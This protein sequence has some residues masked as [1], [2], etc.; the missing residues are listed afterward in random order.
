M[1]KF[2]DSN[3]QETL[4]EQLVCEIENKVSP[5]KEIIA[6]KDFSS[7]SIFLN[8]Q[9]ISLE[10]SFYL[11]VNVKDVGVFRFIFNKEGFEKDEIINQISALKNMII[12]DV[13]RAKDKVNLLLDIVEK[14]CLLFM[15][16]EASDNSYITNEYFVSFMTRNIQTFI[17]KKEKQEVMYEV[18]LVTEEEQD[19]SPKNKKDR[20]ERK[21]HNKVFKK[22]F[23]TV[24]D[25]KFHLLLLLVSTTLFE[26]SIPLAIVNIYGANPI[27]IFLFICAVIGIGMDGYSY[28]DLF[29]TESPKSQSSLASYLSNLLGIG[30]GT[31]LFVLFY[32]LTE[33]AEDVPALGKMILIGLLVCFIICGAVIAITYFIPKKNNKPKKQQD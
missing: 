13:E 28:Y 26:V 7:F 5:I 24:V 9:T 2:I 10:E 14:P 3:G 23:Q 21:P 32:N 1:F 6:K 31:G 25:K 33:K 29:K 22:F 11:Q 27:Y 18:N 30:L 4:Y 8:G 15:I 12:E 17:I 20:T 16:Y 19:E